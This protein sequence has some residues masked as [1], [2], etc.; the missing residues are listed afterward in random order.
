MD[1]GFGQ[2]LDRVGRGLAGTAEQNLDL[3]GAARADGREG[4]DKICRRG[5]WI[6]M[7]RS[8]SAGEIVQIAYARADA[9]D[10]GPEPRGQ[11]SLQRR[12]GT[13]DIGRAGIGRAKLAVGLTV[14]RQ[15]NDPVV[16]V[17][18]RLQ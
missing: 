8:A 13:V 18:Y 1:A 15:Q 12:Y 3:A 10:V 7:V 5:G 9:D 14:G 11:R 2:L 4:A 17:A 6:V 16:A